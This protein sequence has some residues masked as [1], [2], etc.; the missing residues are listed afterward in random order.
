M[1]EREYRALPHVSWSTLK[2]LR[3]SPLQYQHET[4][5]PPE[6]SPA[7]AMGAAIHC[8]CLED[9]A[10]WEQSFA[11]YDGRKDG[12]TKAYQAFLV[13]HAGKT[14]LSKAE[15][16]QAMK[17]AGSVLR[18][19]I[20]SVHM[21]THLTEQACVWTDEETGIE[22]KARVDAVHSGSHLVELKT[23]RDIVPRQFATVAARL[24]YHAQ[25]AM[26]LEATWHMGHE[27]HEDPVIVCV[28]A[29]APHDVA[30]YSVPRDVVSEG[31]AEV[32]RLM[33]LLKRCRDENHWPGVAESVLTFNLPRWAYADAAE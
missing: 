28:Q 6:Q 3:V 19:P 16:A 17:A 29:E 22:C 2:A 26:Y 32:R 30:V 1:N 33:R 15:H 5:H 8:L 7:M 27:L 31:R 21:R 24:G 18:H 10:A 9:E 12:R 14:I 23:T 4:A 20:A 11:V 25:I 13:E